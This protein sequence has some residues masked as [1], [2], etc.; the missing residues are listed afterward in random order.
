MSKIVKAKI[1][2]NFYRQTKGDI[3][4]VK[5]HGL[6]LVLCQENY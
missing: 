4:N 5:G 2:D 3:H 6:G 1:F